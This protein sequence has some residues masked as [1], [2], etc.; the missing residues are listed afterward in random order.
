MTP[1]TIILETLPDSGPSLGYEPDPAT[2]KVRRW[3]KWVTFRGTRR[4][5]EAKLTA[6]LGAAD[7][8]T[9][10]EPSKLTLIGWLR[11]WLGVAIKPQARPRTYTRYRGVIENHISKAMIADLPLQRIRPSHLEAYYASAVGS[12]SSLLTHHTVIRRALRKAVRD[13]LVTVNVAAGLDGRPRRPRDAQRTRGRTV[14]PLRRHR[15]SCS[16]RRR[17]GAAGR[18]V[19]CPGARQRGAQ[20][21]DMRAPVERRRPRGRQPPDRAA[22][23]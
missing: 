13:W 17:Q 22:A 7:G 19:L 5:A 18:G 14:G 8:G 9:F 2:G 21:R 4:K 10:V 11:E 23:R 20:G 6:L 16:P 15:P 12:G 3:Q 1:A